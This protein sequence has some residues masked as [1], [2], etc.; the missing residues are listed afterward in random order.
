MIKNWLPKVESTLSVPRPLGY[1]I[2]A[3]RPDV[4]KTLLD[5]GI[6]VGTFNQDA[7]IDVESY[8][9]KEIVPAKEDYLAPEKLEVVKQATKA[10]VKKGDFYV[11]AAQPAANLISC[12]L[13]PQSEYGLIRYQA[14]KLVPQKG[15][16][17]PILRIVKGKPRVTPYTPPAGK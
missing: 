7:S 3:S 14:Y 5:H 15:A 8:Q 2:P 17:F 12:L 11:A 6:G 1:V 9:I 13:E 10:A 16:E 4:I